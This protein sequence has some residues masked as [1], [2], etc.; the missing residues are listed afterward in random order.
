M[1]MGNG[2]A[3]KDKYAI[4]YF[5]SHKNERETMVIRGYKKENEASEKSTTNK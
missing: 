4:P 5:K 2:C 1:E 3:E